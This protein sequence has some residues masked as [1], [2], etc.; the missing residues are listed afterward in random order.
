MDCINIIKERRSV[1]NFD[2]SFE[3]TDEDIKKIYELASLTPS[4][5]NLQPWEVIVVRSKEKKEL[6]MKCAMNQIKVKHASAN[7]IIIADT[8]AL[9]KNVDDV[10]KSWIE[11][12]YLDEKTAQ[13]YKKFAPNLYGSTKTELKRKIF[14]VKNASFFAMSLMYAAKILGYDSHPMDGIDEDAIKKEFNI[15]EHK[16][17]P[18]VIAVGKH[19]ETK[20]IL[21][22]A[23]RFNFNIKMKI[24]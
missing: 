19:D 13:E 16:I 12:G 1:G 17:I 23:I 14:A 20:K 11:L 9:E 7:F 4:S 10:M 5:M 22:R 6:L 3:M 21:P 24:I 15:A 2:P 18:L 8:D